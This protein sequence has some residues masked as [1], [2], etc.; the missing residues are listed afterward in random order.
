MSA[1]IQK[2]SLYQSRLHKNYPHE[3]YHQR[4]LI[5]DNTGLL[6]VEVRKNT[7][8][9]YQGCF[10]RTTL[11]SRLFLWEPLRLSK[12]T[13]NRASPPPVF[14]GCGP[15]PTVALL[16]CGNT[17]QN[18]LDGVESLH[19]SP[20]TQRAE[21]KDAEARQGYSAKA[22]QGLCR[23]FRRGTKRGWWGLTMKKQT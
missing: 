11:M 9:R 1:Q 20:Q 16:G 18:I 3:T 17:H 19:V 14:W 15:C 23:G 21:G 4:N 5:T 7:L 6:Y 12:A 8:A 2:K 10:F 22:K 13:A